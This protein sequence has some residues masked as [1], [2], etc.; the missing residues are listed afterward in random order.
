[1]LLAPS[2]MLYSMQASGASVTM[3]LPVPPCLRMCALV[4]SHCSW[5]V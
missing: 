1:M 4:L 2:C 3:L 5:G